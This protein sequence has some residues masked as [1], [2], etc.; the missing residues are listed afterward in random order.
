MGKEGE[1]E[2]WRREKGNEEREREGG[3]GERWKE[4]G[5][6]RGRRR[7]RN[8]ERVGREGGEWKWKGGENWRLKKVE[9]GGE[10]GR[11][12][13]GRDTYFLESSV[14]LEYST[15]IFSRSV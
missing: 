2:K 14:S 9:E 8:K 11:V 7:E 12:D 15:D 3:A 1:G 5:K 13:P 4:R 10:E 6:R